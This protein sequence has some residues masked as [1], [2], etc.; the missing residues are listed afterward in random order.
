MIVDHGYDFF[1]WKEKLKGVKG[2]PRGDFNAWICVLFIVDDIFS[3]STCYHLTK[4]SF[5]SPI[6]DNSWKDPLQMEQGHIEQAWS[7][8]SSM[9]RARWSS[10]EGL[11]R[12]RAAAPAPNSTQSK[13]HC[14]MCVS[15]LL[16]ACVPPPSFSF[17]SALWNYRICLASLQMSNALL[18]PR[19]C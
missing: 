19:Q 15:C 5:W 8:C 4:H 3:C 9:D 2:A 18:V 7:M 12:L 10:D 6:V 14:V 17:C 13:V 11:S 1:P 16:Y